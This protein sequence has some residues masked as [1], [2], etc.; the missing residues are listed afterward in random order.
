MKT[1]ENVIDV[2]KERGFIDA[3][4]SEDIRQLT[5]QPIR[6]YCGFD[7]TADSL[8][9]GNMVAIMG[10]AWFQRLGHTPVAIVGG[11]TGMI[12]DP[13]GKSAGRQL[14]DEKSI[15]SNLEGIKNNLRSILD[16]D[17]RDSKPLLLNNYDWYKD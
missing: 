16:F 6:I 12:G 3:L 17:H 5:E 8:H 2:L 13:S 15:E 14:L 9:L 4:T 7:P 1:M 10:L 11:A